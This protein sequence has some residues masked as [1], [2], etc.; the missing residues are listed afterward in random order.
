[1]SRQDKALFT[2]TKIILRPLIH[3]LVKHGVSWSEFNELARESFV[4]VSHNDFKLERKKPSVSRAAVLSG[5]NRKEVTRIIRKLDL[6]DHSVPS[7]KNRAKMVLDG[8]LSDKRFN[9]KGNPISLPLEGGKINFKMLVA[10]YSN[11]MPAKAVLDEL[12]RAGTAEFNA[13]TLIVTLKRKNHSPYKSEIE[14]IEQAIDVAEDH[15]ADI[16]SDL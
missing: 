1:M 3:T 14:L 10:E 4:D 7:S 11:D 6:D 9:K 13:R 2:L 15:M 8:W 12:E 16:F 5:L